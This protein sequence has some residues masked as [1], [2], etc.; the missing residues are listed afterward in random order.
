MSKILCEIFSETLFSSSKLFFGIE[1][2]KEGQRHMRAFQRNLLTL[3]APIPNEQKKLP[4][5]FIFTLLCG[6][7]EGFMKAFKAFIKPF[8]A[9]ERS[10]KLKI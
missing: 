9:P 1:R 7:S 10:F 5:I 6:V 2:K 3:P 4:Q 8:G